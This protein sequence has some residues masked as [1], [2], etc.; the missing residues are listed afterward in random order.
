MGIDDAG[1]RRQVRSYY[2]TVSRY[3]EKELLERHDGDFWR[4]LARA[5][6]DTTAGSHDLHVL[7]LGCGTGRVTETLADEAACVVG[8]DLSPEMLGRARRRLA[9]RPNV[10]LVLA[11]MRSR[12]V[13][14]SFGLVI[15]AN[16]P[17]AHL[18][19]DEDRDRALRTVAHHVHPEEGRFVL[20]AY[21]LGERRMEEAASAGG[22]HRERTVET[23]GPDLHI[24]ETWRCD[25]ETRRC[26][27]RY[28]YVQDERP[29]DEASF[30][31]RLWSVEEI[32]RRLNR[33]GLRVRSLWGGFD[34]RPFEPTEADHLIVYAGAE[35]GR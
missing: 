17:F 25:I 29:V 8:V 20:D 24:R 35:D 28:E 23:S 31:A 1:L 9:H 11:D 27:V 6:R 16:D 32:H 7:D 15:A 14:R 5:A 4:D 19:D 34:R 26:T 2:S 22:F 21:W 13:S 3:I 18:V 10:H 12:C 30:R 33:A